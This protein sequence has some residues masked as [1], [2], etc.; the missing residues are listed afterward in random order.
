LI[1]VVCAKR[2][3]SMWIIFFSIVMPLAFFGMPSLAASV[4]LGLC[5]IGWLIFLLAGGQ[6][7]DLGVQLCERWFLV[8]LY[9]ACGGNAT[10]NSSRTKK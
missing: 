4:F 10:I 1:D 3:G 7:V 2:I 6:V 9:G 5:L 8:A